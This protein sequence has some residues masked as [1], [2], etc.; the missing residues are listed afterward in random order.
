MGFSEAVRSA[1]SKYATFEGRA[2]R[3]E[4]WWFYLFFVILFIVLDVFDGILFHKAMGQ[5]GILGGLFSLAVLLPSLGVAVR[6]LHDVERSGWWLLLALTG[7]GALVLLYWYVTRGT[8]G[9]N[10][11]GADPLS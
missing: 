7:I 11:F 10:A 9:P 2:S 6:R 8:L 1:F 4:Y 3:S 5:V